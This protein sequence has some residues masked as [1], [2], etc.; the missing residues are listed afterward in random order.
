MKFQTISILLTTL[1]NAK[2]S[3]A[4]GDLCHGACSTVG[5]EKACVFTASL[6]L[7]AGE[8][9]YYVFEECGS[10]ANPTLGKYNRSM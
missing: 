3:S 4:D 2:T 6:N 5:G 1:L 9:G 7:S 10:E 8:L